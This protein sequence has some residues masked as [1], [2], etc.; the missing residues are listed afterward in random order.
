MKQILFFFL[1]LFFISSVSAIYAGNCDSFP[2]ETNTL[3]YI[4]SGNSSNTTG[5]NVSLSNNNISICFD[6]SY[7]QDSFT[8]I[9]YSDI[10][11]VQEKSMS[12]NHGGSTGLYRNKTNNIIIE[13]IVYQ[14]VSITEKVPTSENNTNNIMYILLGIILIVLSYLIYKLPRKNK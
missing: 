1:F 14:N 5:M 3:T 9:F 10:I 7:K 2:F 11:G 13:K 6:Y 8:M 12:V 4:T